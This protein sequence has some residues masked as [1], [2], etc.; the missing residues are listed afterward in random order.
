[1]ISKANPDILAQVKSGT[2]VTKAMTGNVAVL[3]GAIFTSFSFFESECSSMIG[4]IGA[5]FGLFVAVIMI[6]FE[7]FFIINSGLGL[8]SIGVGFGLTA[9]SIFVLV[10]M[11]CGFCPGT[12]GP[13]LEE[14]QGQGPPVPG[15]GRGYTQEDMEKIMA[16]QEAR[17]A[18]MQAQQQRLQQQ[19]LAL[20]PP[21]G[22]S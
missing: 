8:H 21:L 9:F 14:G 19:I 13:K 20:A 3:V 11:A 16:M 22:T 7:I 5:Y 15:Q 12:G 4:K 6:G 17:E 2:L 1:M 18:Q 10:S